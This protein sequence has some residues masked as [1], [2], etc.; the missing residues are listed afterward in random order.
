MQMLRRDPAENSTIKFFIHST[1]PSTRPASEMCPITAGA[2]TKMQ[3]AGAYGFV[4][5]AR[6][7]SGRSNMVSAQWSN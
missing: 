6:L 7:L 1:G 2:S 3:A 4:I 5:S